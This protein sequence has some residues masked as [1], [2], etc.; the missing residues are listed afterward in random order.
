MGFGKDMRGK[1]SHDSMVHIQEAEIRLLETV[2]TFMAMRVENDKKYAVG[3][4]K[5]LH[6][7]SSE[8]SEFKDCCSVFRVLFSYFSYV[9]LKV[10]WRLMSKVKFTT[11]KIARRLTLLLAC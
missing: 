11:V 5:M 2:Q 10:G 8:N 3:L 6:K 7:A 4:G 1:L 9:F